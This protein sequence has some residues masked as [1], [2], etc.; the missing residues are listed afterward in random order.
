MGGY[1][2]K[3]AAGRAFAPLMLFHKWF[4]SAAQNLTTRAVQDPLTKK[5]GGWKRL[6]QN[7]AKSPLVGVGITYAL[8]KAW[9]RGAMGEW[10]RE[11]EDNVLPSTQTAAFVMPVTDKG[12]YVGPG[13]DL[14]KVAGKPVV[15][16]PETFL[17]MVLAGI[18]GAFDAATGKSG[19]A[20]ED[21]ARFTASRGAPIVR[22]PIEAL[23]GQRIKD[24][25]SIAGKFSDASNERQA[26]ELRRRGVPWAGALEKL[27]FSPMGTE[28][29]LEQ[30]SYAPSF[31]RRT[32]DPNQTAW[33]RAQ[34]LGSPFRVVEP[35]AK[36]FE[37]KMRDTKR[38]MA[39]ID[40]EN[41]KANPDKARIDALK[42]QLRELGADQQA[43]KGQLTRWRRATQEAES[44]TRP[45][46]E[47]KKYRRL[48]DR[49]R[50]WLKE[51]SEAPPAPSG[52]P[53]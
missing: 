27:P 48:P 22:G 14:S 47:E 15:I 4:L 6:P 43:T 33:E 30:L 1:D 46:R 38:V 16:E 35:N 18:G 40:R 52:G 37:A 2:K 10:G 45:E 53:P 17:Q 50:K 34:T 20:A 49:F 19:R 41:T 36:E 7:M 3:S 29:V 39:E 28:H 23:M 9:N 44:R 26:A 5:W 13:A 8:L 24:S 31:T 51:K 21:L 42:N 32:L 12:E 11:V 25:S